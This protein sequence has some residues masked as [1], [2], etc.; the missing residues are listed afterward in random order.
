MSTL[1]ELPIDRLY[2]A[3]LEVPV[4][5]EADPTGD[6]PRFA[7]MRP[8][9]KPTGSD[10]KDGTWDGTWNS[11]TEIVIANTPAFA[12]TWTNLARGN[13]VLWYTTANSNEPSQ[14]FAILAVS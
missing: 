9:T 14:R 8:G 4:H 13:W 5:A 6:L 1:S 12:T 7:V 3:P 10:W 11:G 2:D